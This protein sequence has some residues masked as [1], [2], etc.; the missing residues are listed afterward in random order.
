M[1]D[2]TRL[3][4]ELGD[5]GGRRI[6]LECVD[7]MRQVVERGGGTVFD[8]IGDELMCTFPQP[9][10][11]A[12]ASCELH[13]EVEAANA[14]FPAPVRVRVGFH[15]G[16][17]LVDGDRIFGETIHVAKR[18]E[19]LAKPQQT[20]TT[21]QSRDLIPSEAK[22]VTRFVDRTHLKG[23][24]ESFELFEIV[25][26]VSAATVRV[27]DSGRIPPPAPPTPELVL[28]SGDQ[29]YTLDA[30]HPTLTLGR[31]P[32]ADLVI[33]HASVSRL[34]ARIEFRKNGFVF[35]DQ[36]TNGSHVIGQ[37]GAPR[38]LRREECPLTGE[39]TIVLGPEGSRRS[40]ASLAYRLGWKDP[41]L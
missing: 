23:L 25:W 17:V 40:S 27:D 15:H 9:A 14:R 33:D 8:R 20:L 41:P 13:R 16:P 6:L 3:Y 32:R 38:F 24:P 22:L 34:H 7:L 35:V 18:V 1:S 28:D 26:D 12:R 4:E 30:A 19:S 36:S 5:E 11:A 21:L 2:S 10:S 39:G 31:D 37:D 29:R